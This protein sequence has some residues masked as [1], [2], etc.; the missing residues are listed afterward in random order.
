MKPSQFQV[1]KVAD[2][3]NIATGNRLT[4]F[5]ITGFWKPILQDIARHRSLSL[6]AGSSRAIPSWRFRRQ[7]LERPFIPSYW[8]RNRPG[9]QASAELTGW[10]RTVARLAWTYGRFAAVLLSF[11]LDKVGLH[12]QLVN[13]VLEPWTVVDLVVSATEWNNFFALRD[14]K[15]AQ[16]ELQAI[17]AAMHVLYRDES[18]MVRVWPGTWSLPLTTPSERAELPVPV[19]KVISTARVARASYHRDGEVLPYADDSRLVARLCGSMPQHLS[20]FEHPAVA[21]AMPERCGNFVGWMQYRK[22]FPDEAGGDYQEIVHAD[23]D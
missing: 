15:D 18:D 12:K 11:V 1:V 9:M 17:A 2:H 5:V 3:L 10:R 4:T 16:P 13:R 23:G 20:P 22:E 7:V 21:L 19:L 14:H 8:G 6:S